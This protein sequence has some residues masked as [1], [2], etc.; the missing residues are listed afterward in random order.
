MPD[1]TCV[2]RIKKVFQLYG[3]V[4]DL[5]RH[6]GQHSADMVIC[7]GQLEF[8]GAARNASMPGRVVVAMGQRGLRGPGLDQ[9]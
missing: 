4:Q 8:R 9:S 5:P 1:W 6:L 3:M 7:Q 2:T